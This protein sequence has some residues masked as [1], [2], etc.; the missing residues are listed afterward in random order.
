MFVA[1]LGFIPLGAHAAGFYLDGS[2][3]Q[4]SFGGVSQSE[5]DAAMVEVGTETFASF[6]L[7]DSSLDKKDMGFAFAVGYQ[8]TPNVAVEAAYVQLGEVGYEADVTVDDGGGPVDL[9][10]GFDF[11]S[12]GPAVTLVGIW[13]VGPSFSLDARAGAYFSKTKVSVFASDGVSSQ[14]DSL[15]SE[16]DTSLLLG[17]GATWSMTPNLGLRF[18]YT[19]INKALAGEGDADSLSLGLRISF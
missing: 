1:V 5:L 2:V 17:V 12:S 13:P 14:S 6:T 15:G 3:I 8:F 7:N 9:T 10:T 16:E 11:K 19:R 4:S 18:G